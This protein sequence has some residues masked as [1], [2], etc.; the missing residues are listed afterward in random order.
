MEQPFLTRRIY[1]LETEFGVICNTLGHRRL[2]ADEAAR[3]LFRDVVAWG[4]SSNVFLANGSRIYLDV[5]SHPEYATAECDDIDELIAHDR[6]GERIFHDLA[7][8]ADG[9]LAEEGID[10]A[11]YLFKNNTDSH[12][13]SYGCHENYLIGRTRELGP[14]TMNLVPFLVSRQLICGAGKLAPNGEYRVSQRAD[15]MWD[16]VSSAT[17]RM[18]PMI[19]TRDEPH[20]D[21][22]RFRRLHVIIGD[23]NMSETSTWLKVG[24]TEL[25]LRLIESGTALRNLALENP[26]RAVR[27]LARDPF[28]RTEVMLATGRTITGLELQQEYLQAALDLVERT[29]DPG[30]R[31]RAVLGLWERVLAAL[32]AK[33]MTPLEADIDWAIKHK[34]LRRYADR[35]SL[36]WTDPRIQQLDLAYHD[37]APGRGLFT[38]LEARGAVS[39]VTD[40]ETVERARTE[41]PRTTRAHLRGA[42]VTAAQAAGVDYS[43]DWTTLKVNEPPPRAWRA[44]D[45]LAKAGTED[46]LYLPVLCKDPFAATDQRV[47]RLLELLARTRPQDV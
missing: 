41:A 21:P 15:H 42:F 26:I 40:D 14:I 34:L 10:G 43:V 39:R 7:Q 24:S 3:H 46:S 31:L 47:D 45:P 4:R 8:R 6:A 9:R 28:G 33:D 13:N 18:R 30:E 44:P 1:G 16:G 12:G 20:A 11:L 25:V 35:N 19:N 5:G 27:E 17:T 2:S 29:G 22:G 36:P 32:E 23:S 37:I 38:L